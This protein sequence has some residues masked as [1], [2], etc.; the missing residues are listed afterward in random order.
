MVLLSMFIFACAATSPRQKLLVGKWKPVKAENAS[1][2][3]NKKAIA[4]LVVPDT[5][6]PK[7]NETKPDSLAAPPS[8]DEMKLTHMI[9]TEMRTSLQLNADKTALR[10]YHGKSMNATW[11][12]KKQGTILTAKNSESGN[13]VDLEIVRLNDTSATVIERFPYGSIRITYHKEK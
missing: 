5:L 1:I 8:K 11:K 6:N 2:P 12:L 9:Q 7:Q 10:F 4:K 13:K 3:E